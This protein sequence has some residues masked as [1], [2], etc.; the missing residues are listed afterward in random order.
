M[1]KVMVAAAM[2]ACFAAPAMANDLKTSG[3]DLEILST[4]AQGLGLGVGV[5]GGLALGTLVITT[6]AVAGSSSSATTTN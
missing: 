1:K 3:D 6:L 2:A 5:T 4:Q